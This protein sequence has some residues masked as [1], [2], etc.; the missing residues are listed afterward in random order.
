MT[1]P[2]TAVLICAL[3]CATSIG[4]AILTYRAVQLQL[5]LQNAR[6]EHADWKALT[7]RVE[8]MEASVGDYGKRLAKAEETVTDAA[9][10]VVLGSKR[11]R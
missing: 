1:W 4:V 3:L 2:A 10:A 8:A 6:N 11:G 7:D 9:S 5:R